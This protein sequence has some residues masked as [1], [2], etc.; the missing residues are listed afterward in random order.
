MNDEAV[1]I[2]VPITKCGD[3]PYRKLFLGDTV[4][5]YCQVHMIRVNDSSTIHPD[6]KFRRMKFGEASCAVMKTIGRL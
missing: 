4:A 3:C 6:C 2:Q 5:Y 1:L